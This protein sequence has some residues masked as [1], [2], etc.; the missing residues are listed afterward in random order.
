[1]TLVLLLGVMLSLPP[2]KTSGTQ[3]N[4]SGIIPVERRI[5]WNAG[6]PGGIPDVPVVADV[7]K[8]GAI[9]DGIADDT[10]AINKAI[11]AVS[12]SGAVLFPTGTYLI[13]SMLKI[14][15]SVVLRGE[16]AAN[17]TLLF[18]VK[19][20]AINVI[21]YKRG[22]WVKL[23]GGYELGSR[24][25]TL[26]STSAFAPGMFVEFQQDNDSTVMYT[27][28]DWNVD[29]A[30][31]SVGQIDVV[32]SVSGNTITLRDPIHISYDAKLNPVIRT[33]GFV[34]YAGLEKLHLKRTD[35]SDS[36]MILFKNSAY[37]WMN[38]VIS[39]LPSKAHVS[40]EAVY[41]CEIRDSYFNDARNHKEG[42]EG[43]GVQLGLHTTNCLIENNIFRRLR[44]AMLVHSGANGNV[45]TYN[46]ARENFQDQMPGVWT[47]PDITLHGHYPYANLFDSNI[48]QQIAI[49]DYW[50]PAGVNNTFCRN[51]IESANSG[52]KGAKAEALV[53]SDHSDSQN[54]IGND[55]ATG[56]II[57]DSSVHN[58]LSHGN[59]TAY[60]DQMNWDSSI[61]GHVIPPSCYYTE[62][63]AFYG[64]LPWPSV[65]A[66]KPSGTIPAKERWLSGQYIP[67]G[68]RD[69]GSY[70]RGQS[71]PRP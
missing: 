29:W 61:T 32:E 24:V 36:Y 18:N 14:R 25:L 55:L 30:A 53:I 17:T 71:Q 52:A 26:S 47:P 35:K 5:A 7:R 43:Y 10:A 42:G 20:D 46:Y 44:H 22:P 27:K 19:G 59:F 49:A 28:P 1:M 51:R 60:N 58:T 62:K 40:T 9:G 65:G 39:E 8:F 6:I 70:G 12:T 4:L 56:A 57:S 41:G 45:F 63:P 3:D 68:T 64:T 48:V 38:E 69:S 16:G 67:S 23:V 21:T 15:K 66:D 54:I 37:V 13:T 2:V 34:T 31:G 50:G 33:Q 11:D